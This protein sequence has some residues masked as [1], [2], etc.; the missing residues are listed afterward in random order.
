MRAPV[1]IGAYTASCA[2]GV[3]H[4]ALAEALAANRSGLQPDADPRLPCWLGRVDALAAEPVADAAWDSRATRLAAGALEQDGF[5]AAVAAACRRHGPA[6]VGLVLGSSASTI[7]VTEQ[8]YRAPAAGGGFPEALRHPALNTPHAVTHFVQR[9]LGLRGP[10]LT[11]STACSSS[12]KALASAERWLHAG[13]ADA[14]VVAGV[15][16]LS[17]SLR[18]GFRAL[19][20]V[21]PGPCRPFAAARRGISLGEAAVFALVERDGDSPLRLLGSGEAN[22][23]HHMSAPHPQ[24]RGAE[25]ALDAALARAGLTAAA[26]DFVNLHGTGTPA[27]DEVEAALVARR[28]AP[29]V[30]ASATKSITGHTMGAAGLLEAVVCWLALEGRVQAGSGQG[31]APDPAFGPVFAA[32]LRAAP[33]PGRARV[34]ASHSFGFGGSNAVLLFGAGA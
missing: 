21:D 18:F 28:Y 31:A 12:A 29:G 20:L 4:R 5:R 1:R 10:A 17:D 26:V 13:V 25:A 16:A 9:T 33:A 14:V 19:G 24:G 27:N 8:A 15:E 6:R 22:D 32:Q 11:V 23:A 3:G 2:A 30:H 7:A 34:A